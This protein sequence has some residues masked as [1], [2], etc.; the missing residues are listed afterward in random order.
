M[1]IAKLVKDLSA[2]VDNRVTLIEDGWEYA[3]EMVRRK[4]VIVVDIAFL[5]WIWVL[6]FSNQK[7][8]NLRKAVFDHMRS[9]ATAPVQVVDA[10][11][12]SGSEHYH[13]LLVIVQEYLYFGGEHGQKNFILCVD[14]RR[15]ARVGAG[16]HAKHEKDGE[17]YEVGAVGSNFIFSSR[18]LLAGIANALAAV[19]REGGHDVAIAHGTNEAPMEGE[20]LA[21][22]MAASHQNSIALVNDSDVL[23]APNVNALVIVA[24]KR[25]IYHVQ[26]PSEELNKPLILCELRVRRFDYHYHSAKCSHGMFCC[27]PSFFPP[28]FY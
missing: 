20:M 6:R 9:D 21:C 14:G 28:F 16:R 10:E 11:N 12:L 2:R 18:Q 5:L 25:R 3:K 24:N 23:I 27:F 26:T 7:Q 17:L 1:G 22:K 19:L 15:E 13:S 4:S 8:S